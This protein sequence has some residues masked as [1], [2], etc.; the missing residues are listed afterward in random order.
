MPLL[1]YVYDL[2]EQPRLDPLPQ[3]PL[4]SGHN[5]H[6]LH[7][8]D[9]RWWWTETHRNESTL[10]HVAQSCACLNTRVRRGKLQ[11][12]QCHHRRQKRVQKW[13]QK[14]RAGLVHFS[15]LFTWKAGEVSSGS[16]WTFCSR[17]TAGGRWL[18]PLGINMGSSEDTPCLAIRSQVWTGCSVLWSQGQ[19]RMQ[20]QRT[21]EFQRL[22]VNFWLPKDCWL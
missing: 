7:I 21:V 2:S 5:K 13:V 3:P 17:G 6:T 12:L 11:H 10:W 4:G 20:P 9:R 22:V 19:V 18:Q 15:L 14:Q 16:L 8:Q 1:F